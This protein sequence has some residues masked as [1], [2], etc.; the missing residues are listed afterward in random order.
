MADEMTWVNHQGVLTNVKLNL[1]YRRVSQ[2]MMKF[3]QFTDYKEAFGKNAGQSV[4]WLKVSNIGTLGGNLTETNTMHESSQALLW[5]T[6]T[7][8]EIG[9]S[10]PYTHKS[11]VLS[12]F[13]VE[14][15]LKTGL[16]DDTAKVVDGLVEIQFASGALK[17]VSTASNHFDLGTNGTFTGTN[18]NVPLNAFHIRKATLE[19]KKRNVPGYLKLGGAYAGLLSVESGESL[20]ADISEN[21]SAAGNANLL[22]NDRGA[23]VFLNGEL[24]V[25]HGMRLAEDTFASR[26]VYDPDARTATIKVANSTGRTAGSFT[27]AAI[28]SASTTG[29]NNDAYFFGSPTVREAIAIPEEIRKKIPDDYGRSKGVAWYAILGFQLEWGDTAAKEAD[30]RIIHWSSE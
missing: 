21:L 8:N 14:E 9:N 23:D 27:Q 28:W 18:T 5:G 17:M 11:E 29:V 24:G 7:V 2:P 30:C 19:L 22:A 13:D 6:V 12:Q 10:V 15:I 20:R 16:V 1:D 4:N 26:F 3:R 25:L